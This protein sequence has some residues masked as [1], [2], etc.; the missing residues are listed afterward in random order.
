MLT[1]AY[2]RLHLIS[3]DEDFRPE[4]AKLGKPLL[5]SY[6]AADTIVLPAMAEL[7]QQT[8]PGCQPSE[9]AG[10]GH[11][12]FLEE[13]ARFNDELAAFARKAQQTRMEMVAN[14]PA[15]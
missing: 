6:G 9:Y 14:V 7:I 13:P 3:R 12:L 1:P 8:C 11:A 5:V 2:V 10:T 4:Y 15:A